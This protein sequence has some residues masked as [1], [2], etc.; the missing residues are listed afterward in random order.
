MKPSK[1]VAVNLYSNLL[2][3]FFLVF[4]QSLKAKAMTGLEIVCDGM[5]THRS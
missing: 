1:Q 3:G 4:P 2:T 5:L